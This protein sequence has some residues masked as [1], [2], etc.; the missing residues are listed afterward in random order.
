MY[1]VI[2]PKDFPIGDVKAV[3]ILSVLGWVWCI[4]DDERDD[5]DMQ[6]FCRDGGLHCSVCSLDDQFQ[7]N[8]GVR[9][10]KYFLGSLIWFALLH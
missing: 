2:Q 3:V 9:Y 8:K 1:L 5:F 6:L 4:T 7:I 10:L